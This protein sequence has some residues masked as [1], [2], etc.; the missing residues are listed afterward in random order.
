MFTA[1]EKTRRTAGSAKS[2][3]LLI[4]VLVL[5]GVRI[6]PRGVEISPVRAAPS[7]AVT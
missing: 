7:V 1:K 2:T 5:A 6:V 3:T 4:A